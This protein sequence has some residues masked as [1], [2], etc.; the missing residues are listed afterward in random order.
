MNANASFSFRL[1]RSQDAKFTNYF[2]VWFTDLEREVVREESCSTFMRVGTNV[3]FSSQIM[4]YLNIEHSQKLSSRQMKI[5]MT[6]WSPNFKQLI[7]IMS[8][9]DANLSLKA[10]VKSKGVLYKFFSWFGL[11]IRSLQRDGS[12]ELCTAGC[13]EP[14]CIAGIAARRR[15][16][17]G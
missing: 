3:H 10:N 12:T 14:T 8:W 9:T 13:I 17:A 2:E 4:F 7:W 1:E 5:R 15:L 16:F 11:D 6:K